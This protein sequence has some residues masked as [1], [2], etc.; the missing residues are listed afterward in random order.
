MTMGYIRKTPAGAW[1]ACW[2]EATGRQP[3]K[4][5]KTRR[6]AS[7]FLATMEASAHN[8]TY[9]DP[10]AGRRIL[11]GR[12]ATQW[13]ASR[14]LELRSA[15][16]DE[17]FMRNHILT[18]WGNAPLAR[19]DH[20]SVQRWI[21]G[22][23]ETRAPATVAVCH[24]LLSSVLEAAVRD[25]L[26]AA[27]P[28]E[29]VRLPKNRRRAGSHKTIS[30]HDLTQK[31]LPAV[32]ERHRG[33][34]GLAGGTGLRWGE[35]IGLRWDSIDLSGST[36]RV[37]RVAVENDHGQVTTKPYPKSRAGHRT[38]PI[39]PLVQQMLK[40][41]RDLYG[42]GPHGEVFVNEAG[43]PLRRGLFR[44][45]VWRPSLVRAGLLGSVVENGNEYQATWPT[46]KDEPGSGTYPTTTQAVKAI[47]H[48]AEGGLR[49]HDLRHSYA[50]WLI[51]SGVPVQDVQRVMGHENPTTTLAIYTHVQ[52]GYENRVLDALAAFSLPIDDDDDDDGT[53]GVPAHP[54]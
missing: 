8:G 34:V 30:H 17:S 4:T 33:V 31:L 48:H 18:Y 10:H 45:R 38:V 47:A 7:A 26:I 41:H 20:S 50:S 44:A 9:V 52:M 54:L 37:E 15:E 16:R 13:L 21:R 27:N 14:T 24:R 11:F 49:F 2:R 6:E 42:H 12:Y 5:F 25:R 19:I 40:Q 43:T 51:T 46:R 23:S 29:G 28:A 3:S 53:S 36:L 22:L 35:V 32:P 39:P 1:R